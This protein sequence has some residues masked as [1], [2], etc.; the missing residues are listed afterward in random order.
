M[1]YNDRIYVMR[2][3]ATG[4][5]LLVDDTCKETVITWKENVE[6]VVNKFK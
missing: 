3:M 1:S 2:M 6:D 5:H 4:G